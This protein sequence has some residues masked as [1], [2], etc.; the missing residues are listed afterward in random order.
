MVNQLTIQLNTMQQQ[1]AQ[2]RAATQQQIQMLQQ[3]LSSFTPTSEGSPAGS[4]TDPPVN[5]STNLPA[6]NRVAKK[7]P[8]LP[9]PPRFNG[10]RKRF[11][12]W[13][14]EMRNKLDIDGPAIGSPSDQFAYVFSRLE[15]GPQAM[16]A[17]YF[18]N[19]GHDGTRNPS[20]FLDYLETCYGD[21]NLEKGALGRLGDMTQGD[22]ESFATFLPRFERE[23]ADSGGATWADAVKINYLS[24]ALNKEMSDRLVAQLNLPR[25][26]P[27]YVNSLQTLGAN[28]DNMRRHKKFRALPHT[29]PSDHIATKSRSQPLVTEPAVDSMDW[30]P[31]RI[32]QAIHKANEKLKGRRAKWVDQ[33]E[34][35]R[36]KS[37]G[38]CLRCGRTGCRV[39]KCPLLPAKRPEPSNG[40]KVA[41]SKPVLKAEVEDEN[42]ESD[43]SPSDQSENESLKE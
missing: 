12:T 16:A 5:Q 42:G 39:N 40:T 33:A 6:E 30:E 35:D 19:G 18:K 8:T 11:R 24:R 29:P 14:L 43:L 22:K 20:R 25:D 37:E 10:I 32:S 21:P 28:I 27:G 9:D 36:R 3:R 23:L 7:K 26:Y 34:I 2:E 41:R 1:Q 13:E 4:P 38:R 31:T 15:E 17:A